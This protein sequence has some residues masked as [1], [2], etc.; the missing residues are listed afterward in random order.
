M[1]P[2]QARI[3]G[4]YI[5]LDRCADRAAVMQARLAAL[6]AQ[7]ILRHRATDGAVLRLPAG[8]SLLPG[9]YACFLSHL[10]VLREA[11]ADGCTLVLEDD[12]ELGAQ[13]PDLLPRTVAAAPPGT[14]IVFF[15]CQPQHALADLSVLWDAASRLLQPGEERRARGVELVDAARFYKW[16]TCAYLVTPQ[17]RERLVDLIGQWLREGPLLPLDRCCERALAEGRLRGLIT[18]PF[19]ATTDLRWHGRSAIGNGNRT[20]PDALMLMRRLLYA[21]PL[22]PAAPMAAALAGAPA[23]PALALLGLVARELARIQRWEATG[24]RAA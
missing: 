19:L 23:D 16:G 5:N 13:F 22:E 20:P 15:E 1:S 4:R 8:C 7:W 3:T 10:E 18:V 24:G 17:G 12:A 14:D 11:P 6:G 21:G 9:E 2:T